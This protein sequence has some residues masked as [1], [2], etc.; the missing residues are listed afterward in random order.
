MKETETERKSFRQNKSNARQGEMRRRNRKTKR[1]K[2]FLTKKT[3]MQDKV[4]NK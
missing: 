1:K 4:R 2:V 3:E